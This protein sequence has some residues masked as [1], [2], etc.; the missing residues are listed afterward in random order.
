MPRGLLVLSA[1][2]IYTHGSSKTIET[3][4]IVENGQ[5]VFQE[6]KILYFFHY[7]ESLEKK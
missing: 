7:E 5:C 3:T 6:R 1:G 2:K 4:W